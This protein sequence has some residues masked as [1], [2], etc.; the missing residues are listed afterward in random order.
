MAEVKTITA[1]EFAALNAADYTL[2]DVRDEAEIIVQPIAGAVQ[3]PFAALVKQL[4]AQLERLPKAKPVLVLCRTGDSSGEIAELLAERGYE[5]LNLAGGTQALAA[6]RSAHPAEPQF[7]DAKA[8]RCPGPIVAVSDALKALP[9]GA[10]V[11]V[12]ATEAAFESDVQVW[13]RRTGNELSALTV[14]D[15]VIEALV[16]KRT[17]AAAPTAATAA[18]SGGN[19]KTFVIFS[20]DLDKAIA[21]FIMANGAAAMGRTVTLFFTFWGLNILRRAK[22]VRVRKAFVE[23]MFGAMMPRGSRRLGLSRMNMGGMGAKM[24]RWVMKSKN[25]ASL[26]SLMQSAVEH[27]VRIVACQ[28]SM[29]IMGIRK[30]ELVDGVELGGVATFLGSCETSDATLFI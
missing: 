26:E 1:A 8:L 27:G 14:R 18:A 13:C 15:G 24:I 16:T 19:D 28:M 7:I 5:A 6:Y 4:S 23:R 22:K 25:V 11:R 2:L 30:E 20:G 21:A 17:H 3:I 12:Q 10:Q 9:D 29:D